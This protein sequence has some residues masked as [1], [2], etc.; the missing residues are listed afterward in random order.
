MVQGTANGMKV[1]DRFSRIRRYVVVITTGRSGSAFVADLVNKNALNASSEHEPNLAPVDVSTQWYYDGADGKLAGL[2]DRKIARLRR[3]EIICSVP[4]ADRLYSRFARSKTK[5]VIPRV[6]LREVYVEVDNGFLKSYGHQLLDAIPDLEFVHL[7]RNPLLQAKSAENRKSHPSPDRPYFLWPTW[8]R[9]A[10]RLSE[11]ATAGL[12]N[13]QL[14]LW[15][16]FEMELRYVDFLERRG[17]R[18]RMEVCIDDLNTPGKAE[19]LFARIGV[20]HRPLDLQAN[21]N[22]GPR[23]STITDRE[24]EE[25][26]AFLRLVPD[27]LM[28]KLPN[29]YGIEG[30]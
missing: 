19:E 13:F 26:T 27:H 12:S 28:Q 22:L 16:W 18:S 17:V 20:R 1:E 5:R 14:A 21:R 30:L 3:G 10:L 6:P 4:F 15:Y 23:K 8:R 2:V 11:Q 7:T 24:H 29:T 9:N 25:A